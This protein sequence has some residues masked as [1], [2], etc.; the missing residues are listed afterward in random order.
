MTE[1]CRFSIK[2]D[3]VNDDVDVLMVAV[4]MHGNDGLVIYEAKPS[5]RSVSRRHHLFVC[6]V[7]KLGPGQ[8]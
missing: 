6:R 7:F 1:I 8:N 3:L 4:P 5:K 2:T